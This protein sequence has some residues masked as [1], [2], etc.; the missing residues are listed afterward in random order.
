VSN[1]G[2]EEASYVVVVTGARVPDLGAETPASGT[3]AAKATATEG[4]TPSPTAAATFDTDG[5]GLNN[6]R[7]AQLGT[8]PNNPDTDGDGISD[9]DQVFI[10]GTDPLDPKSKP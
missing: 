7:E 9:G 8:D 5:D 10:F 3:P 6:T 2:S 4:L 1:T